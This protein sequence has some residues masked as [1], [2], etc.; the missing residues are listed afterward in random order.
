MLLMRE[1][2]SK[3]EIFPWGLKRLS[4]LDGVPS[5]EKLDPGPRKGVVVLEPDAALLVP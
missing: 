3:E 5:S 1:L 4:G 2:S